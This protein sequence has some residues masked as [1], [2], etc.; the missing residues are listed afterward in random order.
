MDNLKC[1]AE[2]IL[3]RLVPPE[4]LDN[5]ENSKMLLCIT[6]DDNKWINENIN[7]QKIGIDEIS[8]FI[9]TTIEGIEI[10]RQSILSFFCK[11]KIKIAFGMLLKFDGNKY[12]NVVHIAV[13]MN[14]EYCRDM[15]TSGWTAMKYED[16]FQ[17][18]S[19][20]ILPEGKPQ[21]DTDENFI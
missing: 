10:P 12:E 1:L 20:F 3:A 4:N 6:Y 21:I 17:E 11:P 19:S 16:N 5:S 7:N 2:D 8:R 9:N 14:N 18:W 15:I 13:M